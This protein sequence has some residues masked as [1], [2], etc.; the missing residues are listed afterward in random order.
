MRSA[1]GVWGCSENNRRSETD[2]A[3]PES[4]TSGAK[5]PASNCR[6]SLGAAFGNKVNAGVRRELEPEMDIRSES[7]LLAS[8]FAGKLDESRGKKWRYLPAAQWG[9]TAQII[10]PLLG[11]QNPREESGS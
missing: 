7:Q 3:R 6:G 8:D 1:L 4:I 9:K 5:L 10:E 2:V 11:Q